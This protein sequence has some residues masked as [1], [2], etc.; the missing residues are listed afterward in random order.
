[1]KKEQVLRAL[2]GI[3]NQVARI[4]QL[5]GEPPKKR[6][7]AANRDAPADTRPPKKS[8][9][10]SL[11]TR[12]LPPLP[13]INSE[14]WPEAVPG[15]LI[16]P[17][18][19]PDTEKQFRAIQIAN[20]L[21][22][23]NDKKVLDFGCGTGHVTVEIATRGAAKAVGYDIKESE[24]WANAEKAEFVT[25]RD[26]A[27]AYSPYDIILVYDVFDH[28]TNEDPAE[29]LAWLSHNLAG[30]G[31]MF[32]RVHPWT[33]RHGSHSYEKVNKAYVHLALTAEEMAKASIPS[34]Q[35]LQLNKPLAAYESWIRYA[36]LKVVKREIHSEDVESFLSGTQ[37]KRIIGI[38][39][40]G[41]QTD[42]AAKKVLSNQ[43]IDYVLEPAQSKRRKR[44]QAAAPI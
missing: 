33:S 35:C 42:D 2:N 24:F 27:A 28:M 5:L 10:Q 30:N 20:M 17:E 40:G 44:D 7:K 16:V 18:D 21:P 36:G 31:Q 34:A 8:I 29:V 25:S 32:V 9:A 14:K 15:H 4:R 1:M 38:V 6:A 13:D 22:E 19:A 43:F 3:E 23:L 11:P 12:E 41:K 39:W 26:K 37:Q